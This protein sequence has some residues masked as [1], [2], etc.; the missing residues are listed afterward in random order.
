MVRLDVSL[1]IADH[2]GRVVLPI[3]AF[4]RLQVEAALLPKAKG[5][6]MHP[7]VQN[8]TPNQPFWD[9]W[10]AGSTELS[11]IVVKL[12]A[13]PKI[14]T[15]SLQDEMRWTTVYLR[16]VSLFG[17]ILCLT[18]HVKAH[19]KQFFFQCL[20]FSWEAFEEKHLSLECS[21]MYFVYY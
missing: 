5:I 7:D 1:S 13:A 8:L 6:C 9:C 20:L 10:A 18:Q 4:L 21:S 12:W 2:L 17:T 15:E 11:S 3:T 16:P 14:I 19:R